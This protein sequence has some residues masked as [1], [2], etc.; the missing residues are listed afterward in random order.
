MVLS[1]R[2]NTLLGV[3]FACLA[4]YTRFPFVLLLS[5]TVT[6]EVLETHLQAA[7][8]KVVKAERASGLGVNNDGDLEVS[9]DSGKV[10]KAKYV[11]GADGVRSSVS[12]G[13]AALS[14]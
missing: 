3:D 8:I 13:D 1:N 11:V 9:F 4:P 6:E 2:S 10:V 7:A 12:H 14:F 5:Q